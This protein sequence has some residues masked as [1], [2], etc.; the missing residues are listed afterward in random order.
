MCSSDQGVPL[1][2]RQVGTAN[3]WFEINSENT[4][5]GGFAGGSFPG[6][7]WPVTQNARGPPWTDFVGIKGVQSYTNF[8]VGVQGEPGRGKMYDFDNSSLENNLFG[9]P[10]EP[11]TWPRL[12]VRLSAPR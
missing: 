7:P 10:A 5:V 3:Y 6:I 11:A 8:F 12:V 9:A 4:I 2:P 1:V